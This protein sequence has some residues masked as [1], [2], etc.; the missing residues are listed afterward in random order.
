[1]LDKVLLGRILT[2]VNIGLGLSEL[3][4][5]QVDVST[6][7][8]YLTAL[9]GMILAA[10]II[11]LLLLFDYLCCYYDYIHHN[12][13]VANWII[14]IIPF[15]TIWILAHLINEGTD[16]DLW[17]NHKAL[18]IMFIT[19]TFILV[20]FIVSILIYVVVEFV[21]PS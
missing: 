10:A 14:L 2:L 8:S 9:W 15:N 1:M 21:K 20:L 11:H 16:L 19:E 13:I 7:R 3:V 18:F 6:D 5:C 17:T 4:V 12:R